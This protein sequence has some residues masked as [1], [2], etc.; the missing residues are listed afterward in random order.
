MRAKNIEEMDIKSKAPILLLNDQDDFLNFHPLPKPRGKLPYH[1]NVEEVLKSSNDITEKLVF[2]M[3]G[4]TGS[5]RH[6]DFQRLVANEMTR[7][8]T[9]G[10]G[11]DF[12]YHLG[13]V[14]YNFGEALEY[15]KQFFE[16]YHVYPSPIFAIAG[17]HDADI[18]PDTELPY[19]SLDAFMD[20]FCDTTTR[21]IQFSGKTKRNSMVQPHV[22]WTLKTPLANLIGLYGNTPKFGHIDAEQKRWFIEELQKASSE[23][24]KALLVCLHQA[25]YSADINHGSS[26]RMISFLQ[27]AF[28]EAGVKPDVV[29]SGHVHNYQRFIQYDKNGKTT[30]YIVSGAGGYA[31][32]HTIAQNRHKDLVKTSPLFNGVELKNYCDD[33][34]G[35][36]KVTIEKKK[37]GLSLMGEYYTI[38]HDYFNNAGPIASLFERFEVPIKEA[39]E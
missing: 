31:D 29:F 23:H 7:Q 32:L 27:A 6:S 19:Q 35:F 22:Y 8:A 28:N 21:E 38:R 14:V 37:S 16:P 39:S 36:L 33:R 3:V 5:A 17:N 1:L 2:H 20:V 13:D 30:P 25:P 18:N 9:E 15:P 24:E 34:H 4:D 10:D 26:V 12:L 11:V